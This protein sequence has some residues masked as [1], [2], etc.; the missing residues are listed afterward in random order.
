MNFLQEI[1]KWKTDAY[2]ARS[3]LKSLETALAGLKTQLAAA[4]DRNDQLN[5]TIND[6]VSKIRE[7]KY[8]KCLGNDSIH[9]V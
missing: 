2:S 9:T 1:Q 4:T 3:E 6:H 7:R 5:K 8:S